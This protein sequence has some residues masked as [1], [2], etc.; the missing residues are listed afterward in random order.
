MGISPLAHVVSHAVLISFLIEKIISF[1]NVSNLCLT[2]GA[3]TLSPARSCACFCEPS[4]PFR[5]RNVVMRRRLFFVRN[6]W[7]FTTNSIYDI[8]GPFAQDFLS[9]DSRNIY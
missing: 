5:A 4:I 2:C 9:D 7:Y 1:D 8:Y 3:I 6:I